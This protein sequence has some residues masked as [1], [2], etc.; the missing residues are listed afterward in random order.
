MFIEPAPCCIHADYPGG[1][2]STVKGGGKFGNVGPQDMDLNDAD[3]WD[4]LRSRLT[5]DKQ[6]GAEYIS[7]QICLPPQHMNTVSATRLAE[8]AASSCTDPP[9]TMQGGTYRDDE[10]YLERAAATI[11]ALQRECFVAGLNFY[12]ETHVDR[13]SEDMV[14]NPLWNLGVQ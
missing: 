14:R 10:R 7:F 12:V 2:A 5:F 11:A 4:S 1:F 9:P 6:L 8:F 13:L 3:F